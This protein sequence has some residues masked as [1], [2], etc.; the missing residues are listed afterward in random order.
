MSALDYEAQRLSALVETAARFVRVLEIQQR[1]AF[2]E[3]ARDLAEENRRVID[4]RVKA[5]DVSP[6][7][8]IKA[9]LESESGRITTE[10]L[11]REL[12]AARRNLSAM[13]DE[14]EP[15]FTTAVGSLTAIREVPPLKVL[16]E[17]VG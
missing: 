16:S 1:V 7:D 9:R 4:Q 17:Q 8:E 2:A 5:G 13:W 15:G 6:I 14:D 12:E 10:R 11:K 3:R